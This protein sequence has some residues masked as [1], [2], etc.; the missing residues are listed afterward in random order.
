MRP[1]AQTF[2]A[3][4]SR[5]SL[6]GTCVLLLAFAVATTASASGEKLTGAVWDFK[7]NESCTT[8][9]LDQQPP[10]S[11]I[12]ITNQGGLPNCGAHSTATLLDF[13]RFS[14]NPDAKGFVSPMLLTAEYIASIGG[15]NF[16]A[17]GDPI[18]MAFAALRPYVNHCDRT[19]LEN[20]LAVDW[21]RLGSALYDAQDQR[22]PDLL[23]QALARARFPGG[24]A[25]NLRP[26]IE[27]VNVPF[28]TGLSALVN[29]L[30]KGA[31]LAPPPPLKVEFRVLNHVLPAHG[32]S[33]MRAQLDF[34]RTVDSRL[35]KGLPTG[36]NY[37]GLIRSD[38]NVL[39][40]N[41]LGRIASTC[42]DPDTFSLGHSSVIAG[43][44]L[45]TYRKPSGGE[46]KICQYLVRDNYGTGYCRKFP[47]DPDTVPPQRCENGQIWIDEDALFTN[48]AELFWYSPK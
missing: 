20:E 12:P 23:A 6:F 39:G 4:R 2:S 45:L 35:E 27:Y 10:L 34:R 8:V 19:L 46:G 44:R 42:R 29:D 26:T 18:D 36:I 38:P 13:E 31:K 15:K 1:L 3:M 7:S 22:R 28:H 17:A 41:H 5:A 37:C 21:A 33:A 32:G 47:D 43:R 40:L 9:R 16:N 24:M 30:C 25:S 14:R 48:T 11:R